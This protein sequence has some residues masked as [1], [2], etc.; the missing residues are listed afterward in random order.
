MFGVFGDRRARKQ[1]DEKKKK[2][3]LDT[4]LK[5]GHKERSSDEAKRAIAYCQIS[6]MSMSG[7]SLLGPVGARALIVREPATT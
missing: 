4:F 1:D 5:E 7:G 6:L 2:A 3:F